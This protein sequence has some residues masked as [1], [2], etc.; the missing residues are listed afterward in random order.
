MVRSK[1][2]FSK[3]AATSRETSANLKARKLILQT[4]ILDKLRGENVLIKVH[5]GEKNCSTYIR[6][7]TVR[8]IVEEVWENGGKP[9]VAETTT[10]YSRDRYTPEELRATAT[11]NGYT[12]S[13]L[14]CPFQVADEEGGIPVKVKGILP[15]VEVAKSIYDAEA[16]IVITHATLH[17]WVAGFAGALKQLGMGCVTKKTKREI[18]RSTKMWV[19]SDLCKGCKS[20][21]QV[22]KSDGISVKEKKAII[23]EEKC[24]RCGVCIASCESGAILHQHD[25]KRFAQSLVS[26]ADGVIRSFKRGRIAYINFLIDITDHC[27]CEYFSNTPVFPN[28]AILSSEDPVAIDMASI[29]LINMSPVIPDSS[30]DRPEVKKARDKITVITGKEWRYQVDGGQKLRIGRKKYIMSPLE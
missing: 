29:D 7:N 30:A 19:D 28:I 25:V 16:M 3:Y 13:A 22:C 6:P 24:A 4:G 5:P 8:N 15:E 20:C 17:P 10:L 23:D 11:A 18:H 27:D 12:E 9:V 14:E 1:V 26:S 2:Y 21:M